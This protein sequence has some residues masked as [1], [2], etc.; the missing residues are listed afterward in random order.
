MTH[1]G[2]LMI[3]SPGTAPEYSK[4]LRTA[5][6]GRCRLVNQNSTYRCRDEHSVIMKQKL[7]RAIA[8]SISTESATRAHFA[9]SYITIACSDRCGRHAG[10]RRAAYLHSQVWRIPCGGTKDDKADESHFR[11]RSFTSLIILASSGWDR[12]P[13]P[14]DSLS[15]GG[16]SLEHLDGPISRADRSPTTGGP[17]SL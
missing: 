1:L 2:L 9:A 14:S 6:L 15:V 8:V 4:A 3:R 7:R 16:S 5:P 11:N 10:S 12:P 13:S 17:N